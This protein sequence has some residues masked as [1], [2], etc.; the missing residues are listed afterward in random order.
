MNSNYNILTIPD[1]NGLPIF[2]FYGK[3]IIGRSYKKKKIFYSRPV[4]IFK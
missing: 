3:F 1:K 4:I 2:D